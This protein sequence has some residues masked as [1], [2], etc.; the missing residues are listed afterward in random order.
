MSQF[1]RNTRDT[2]AYKMVTQ[3]SSQQNPDS[4]NSEDKRLTTRKKIYEER[5]N[6]IRE[7]RDV[8]VSCRI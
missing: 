4:E 5:I 3:E 1:T 6:K 2:E 7:T 8:T